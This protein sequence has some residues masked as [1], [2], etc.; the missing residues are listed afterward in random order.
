[1]AS[2]LM[3]RILGKALFDQCEKEAVEL[4]KLMRRIVTNRKNMVIIAGFL[5]KS[6]LDDLSP[7]E[8]SACFADLIEWIR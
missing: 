5:L 2:D 3:Q 4:L 7:D 8:R 6:A 1:M